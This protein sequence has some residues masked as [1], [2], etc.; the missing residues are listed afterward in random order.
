MPIYV[1]KIKDKTTGKMI[2][3]KVDG[4][5][6]YYIRTYIEDGFGNRKQITRH[7]K[8][9]LG[10][11]GY[12]LA[13]QEEGRLKNQVLIEEEKNKNITLH[14]LKEMYLKE[15]SNKVDKDTLKYKETK[16]N[17]FCEFDP[18]N[19]IKTFP[20]KP[21]NTI[22]KELYIDWQNQM[23]KKK[24]KR[25]TKSENAKTYNYS[26][27]RLNEIH[28]EIVS[29]F[30]FAILNGF[31]IKNAP[32]QVGKFG[33]AKEIKLSQHKKVYQTITYD[34]YIRL[35]NV[36]KDDLKYN[37]IF[38]LMFSRGP[39]IGEIRAF[40]IKD[41]NYEK[42]QLMVNHTLSKK[43]ELKEPKTASSKNTIDLD[44]KLNEKIH[45][46]V[47]SAKENNVF[48]E[49]WFLF[50]NQNNPISAHA[51]DHS[52]KKYF[53]MANIEKNIRLHDFRHSCATWLFSLGIPITVISRILRHQDINTTMKTYTHLLENDYQ[54]SLENLN[55]LKKQD[56][57]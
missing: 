12:D 2:E 23:K 50:G 56:Q 47:K 31:P 10:R 55:N 9:W 28:N 25:C 8:N 11:A 15:C 5:K 43:N 30:D 21:I 52:K 57:K 37:T 32:K 39:R 19:Q 20:N 4:K 53:K 51:I 16:L 7:N 44:D 40:K 6:Q 24:Y 46:L 42:K 29:M 27:Q 38:D 18:T 14:E 48:N 3:K 33:T 17:H 45:Q 35:M 34:E 41:Y 36:T 49:E 1:E 54:N 22:T 13:H 26:I